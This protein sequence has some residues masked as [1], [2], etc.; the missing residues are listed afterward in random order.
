MSRD[1]HLPGRSNVLAPSC[2]ASTS[3]PLATSAALNVL[4]EGG[5]A[6]DAALT[7]AAVLA[8]VEPQMTGIGGDCFALVC[9]P[10]G[11]LHGLN[12]SGRSAAALNPTS[13]LGQGER[14]PQDSP[15]TV[16][17]RR[18]ALASGTSTASC[19]PA[20]VMTS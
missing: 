15:H 16:T 13:L 19:R 18:G 4:R 14:L 3:H 8:V 10:D 12:G 6:V 5:N 20:R 9:E 17:V 7:A 2:M 1:F 11:Q